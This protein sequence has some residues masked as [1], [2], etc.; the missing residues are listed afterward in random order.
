M[1]IGIAGGGTNQIAGNS[2]SFSGFNSIDYSLQGGDSTQILRPSARILKSK[3]SS[4]SSRRLKS[5]DYFYKYI[6]SPKSTNRFKTNKDQPILSEKYKHFIPFNANE[7]PSV[8]ERRQEYMLKL[9][10]EELIR[11]DPIL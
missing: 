11:Y 4:I 2:V 3:Q 6:L 5:N 9:D 7:K 1:T 10:N 8:E